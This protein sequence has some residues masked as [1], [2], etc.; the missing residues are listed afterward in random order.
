[1]SA[2]PE[3]ATFRY[4]IDRLLAPISATAPCGESLRETAAW[5]RIKELRREDNPH[6]PQGVWEVELK[7][8][9]WRAV[10]KECIDALESRSKDLQMAVWLSE[11]WLRLHGFPGLSTG[12]Q[13]LVELIRSFWKEI[14]PQPAD[15]LEFRLG[16]L[17]WLDDRFTQ[18]VKQLPLTMPS[19]G[20]ALPYTLGD[21]EMARRFQPKGRGGTDDGLSMS[22]IEQ[23][24][25]LT[26]TSWLRV[27]ARSVQ[28]C[29]ALR[30]QLFIELQKQI[31][32]EA[33][34]LSR[35]RDALESA[36]GL[37]YAAL[38]GRA[39]VGVGHEELVEA[40][41]VELTEYEEPY[42]RPRTGLI[43]SRAE[44]YQRLSEAAEY[45]ARTEPHSPVPYLVRRAILWGGLT[46]EEL[47]PQLIRNT[48]ELDEVSRLL[49][50]RAD[51]G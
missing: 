17:D 32:D 23:S 39:D 19:A 11:A 3:V 10:E 15:D 40:E 28:E 51:G 41:D 42:E 35:L 22:K 50:L 25:G 47:L 37:V 5:T 33:P 9:D 49:Q 20:D 27:T 18:Q 26:P 13:L 4:D 24:A 29:S 43:R 46:L 31:G 7:K 30:Q 6:L 36:Y 44:A 34:P 45:L 1:M 2:A 12:L 14:Y 8:A 21:W 48:N 38:H 16:P